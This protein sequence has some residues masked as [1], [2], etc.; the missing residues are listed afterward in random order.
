MSTSDVLR[1][2]EWRRAWTQQPSS[3]RR[4]IRKACENGEALDD[5]DLAALAVTYAHRQ[6]F[7][8][9]WFAAIFVALLVMGFNYAVIRHT[10]S[11]GEVL[12]P[13][14][15]GVVGMVRFGMRSRAMMRAE[16]E[17][18][19]FLAEPRNLDA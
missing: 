18:E 2:A 4:E 7:S 9:L 11:Y 12:T 3:V 8:I 16:A 5:S 1:G 6:K 19:R 17:N 15:F 10:K 13:I 14:G